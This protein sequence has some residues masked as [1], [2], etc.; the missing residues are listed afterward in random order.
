ML[1]DREWGSEPEILA[2]SKL[3]S[4]NIHIFDEMVS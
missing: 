3:Y 4:I 1:E 2:F